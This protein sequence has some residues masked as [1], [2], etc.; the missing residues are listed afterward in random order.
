MDIVSEIDRLPQYYYVLKNSE[1]ILGGNSGSYIEN[2]N[3][4]RS[5]MDR[6]YGFWERIKDYYEKETLSDNEKREYA[7]M[8]YKMMQHS[9]GRKFDRKELKEIINKL[10]ED[11][12]EEIVWQIDMYKKG[13]EYYSQY[14]N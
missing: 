6:L 3:E 5:S 12:K 8:V 4:H 1:I 13:R 14:V 2:A 9:E 7:Q 11:D 10:S